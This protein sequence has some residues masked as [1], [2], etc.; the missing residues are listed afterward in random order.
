MLEERV[1]IFAESL[2]SYWGKDS[3]SFDR[4]GSLW[5]FLKNACACLSS[6]KK[7]FNI[8]KYLTRS[9]RTSSY[10]RTENVGVW[11]TCTLST[12]LIMIFMRSWGRIMRSLRKLLTLLEKTIPFWRMVLLLKK[13]NDFVKKR[14][15][16]L[17]NFYAFLENTSTWWKIA[18][19]S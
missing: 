15:K 18:T 2:I 12:R 5:A 8:Q 3:D 16:I 17:M 6:H 14:P 9:W 13:T 7:C 10:C 4:S 19:D 11:R 1:H